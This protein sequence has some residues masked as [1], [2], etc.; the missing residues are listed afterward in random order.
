M[1][2]VQSLM[3]N[4]TGLMLLSTSEHRAGKICAF[5]F[6]PSV[7]SAKNVGSFFCSVLSKLI[8]GVKMAWN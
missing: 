8:F 1:R 2:F 4:Y 6:E 3:A 5:D 7:L